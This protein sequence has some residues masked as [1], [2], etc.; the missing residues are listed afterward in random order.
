MGVIGDIAVILMVTLE[1]KNLKM[2]AL[3]RSDGKRA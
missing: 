2:E 1:K 3:R